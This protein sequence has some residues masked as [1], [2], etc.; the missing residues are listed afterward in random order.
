MH[1]SNNTDF[2]QHI[3]R[4]YHFERPMFSNAE[5]VYKDITVYLDID[6]KDFI[7]GMYF[8][9]NE[10]SFWK[11]YLSILCEVVEGVSITNAR[12]LGVEIFAAYLGASKEKAPFV[13]I[14]LLLLNSA[15]DKY[16]G[17]MGGHQKLTN[18]I[19][20]ELICR[21]FGCYK[22]Q[23]VE[24]CRNNSSADLNSVS[25][26]FLAGA[27]CSSCQKDIKHIIDEQLGANSQSK[28]LFVGGLTPAQLVLEL[29]SALQKMELDLEII[30]LDGYHLKLKCSETPDSSTV[31][32]VEQQIFSELKV[33]LSLTFV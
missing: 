1:L 3:A 25:Q 15:L 32:A 4:P 30:D 23:I 16:E 12:E 22:G 19:D 7:S 10:D 29:D 18:K 14:A 8:T 21:C 28:S 31:E 13:N 2:S 33:K 27:G 5:I 9:A 24:H 6:K 17:L 11:G 26:E 20:D